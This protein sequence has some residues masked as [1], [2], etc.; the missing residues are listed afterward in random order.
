MKNT[1][2]TTIW[3]VLDES[4]RLVLRKKACQLT[5]AQNVASAQW[6]SRYKANLQSLLKVSVASKIY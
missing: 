4:H 6:T 1:D 5:N 3:H 2:L